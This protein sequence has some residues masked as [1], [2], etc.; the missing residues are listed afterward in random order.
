MKN[1]SNE[2]TCTLSIVIP[3]WGEKYRLL[4]PKALESVHNQTYIPIEVDVVTEHHQVAEAMNEG[5]KRTNG[6]YLI[7]LGADDTLA[8][9]YVEKC[10]ALMKKDVGFVYTGCETHG[11]E[12]QVLLPH[13]KHFPWS[14]LTGWGGQIGAALIKRKAFNSIG[15]FDTTLNG[16]E[17]FDLCLRMM[18]KGWKC[19][20]V[21]EPLHYRLVTEDLKRKYKDRVKSLRR[22]YPVIYG[23]LLVLVPYRILKRFFR[24]LTH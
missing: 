13:K 5:A 10:M 6:E 9:S 3:C 24:R 4:L 16:H 1:F 2:A 7:F 20:A 11:I 18:F 15:G 23:V 14:G 8:P 21:D 17:D 12:N 19:A 22:K